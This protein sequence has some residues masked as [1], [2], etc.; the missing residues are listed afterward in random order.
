M[1]GACMCVPTVP[2][3][4]SSSSP[5]TFLPISLGS[6]SHWLAKPRSWRLH[7]WSPVL[8]T[9]LP[10]TLPSRTAVEKVNPGKQRKNKTRLSQV[11]I[12]LTGEFKLKHSKD[13]HV[14]ICPKTDLRVSDLICFFSP[15]CHMWAK[16]WIES[17]VL[18][19][20]DGAFDSVHIWM[21]GYM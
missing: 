9:D 11:P 18:R 6:T 2:W 13:F 10:A 17:L 20:L 16:I 19:D 7:R 4:L 3:P 5:A 14:W 1:M 8:A 15:F 21:Q 12:C